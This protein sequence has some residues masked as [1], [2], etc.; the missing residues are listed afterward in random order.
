MDLRRESLGIR[1]RGKMIGM[2]F[3]SYL[4]SAALTLGSSV[5]A[6]QLGPAASKSDPAAVTNGAA[7]DFSTAAL[8]HGGLAAAPVEVVDQYEEPEYT[9]DFLRAQ[10]RP[11]DPIYLY[12]TR[13]AKVKKPPVVIYLYGYPS[14]TDLFSDDEWCK[15]TTAN[16]YASVGFAPFLTGHRYHDVPLKEWFVS[17]LQVSLAATAHDVEMVLNYLA[18]RG[19]VDVNNAGIFGVGAGATIAVTAAS[20]DPRIKAI[21][22]IDPWGDW[23]VWLSQSKVVPDSE[24]ADYLKPDF[25]RAVGPFDPV[26]L[27]PGLKTPH[28]GI[29]QRNDDFRSTPEEAK[30]RMEDALPVAAEKHRFA[31][32]AEFNT[33]MAADGRHAY[34]WL[35]LRLNPAGSKSA[36]AA[37]QVPRNAEGLG[38]P[39]ATAGSAGK[40]E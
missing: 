2:K 38:R 22:L 5:A 36:G 40:S 13:P 24:R 31:N 34:D 7:E 21:E 11:G 29:Y 27:L 37:K 17:D 16:G 10:W 28:I 23:P 15:H 8:P 9:Q 33:T 20:V 39:N 25:L 18:E 26:A 35:K 19:D 1:L 3:V 6:A 14:E 4:L 32:T 12:V 30:K